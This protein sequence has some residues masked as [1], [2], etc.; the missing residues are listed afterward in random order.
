MLDSG[1]MPSG[2]DD[3]KNHRT[4]IKKTKHLQENCYR[5]W[6]LAFQEFFKDSLKKAFY[7]KNLILPII[8]IKSTSHKE[9]RLDS[10]SPL[11]KSQTFLIDKRN[12][13]LMQELETYPKCAHDD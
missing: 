5:L 4:N 2:C 10:L 3:W 7:E 8:G 6:D 13:L 1:F 11:L 9:V 12:T